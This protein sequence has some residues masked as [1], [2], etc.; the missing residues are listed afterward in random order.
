MATKTAKPEKDN[1]EVSIY[2]DYTDNVQDSGIDD[3]Q[4][5]PEEFEG[6]ASSA[7]QKLII[8]ARMGKAGYEAAIPSRPDVKKKTSK[9]SLEH[10]ASELVKSMKV[11][12]WDDFKDVTSYR[13]LDAGRKVY[14]YTGEPF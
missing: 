11:F 4:A 12:A 2:P 9:V 8:T 1:D 3:M 10:A 13:D 14:E 5:S 6:V 7:P